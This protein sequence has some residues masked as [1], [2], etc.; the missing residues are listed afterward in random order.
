MLVVC[1]ICI[2]ELYFVGCIWVGKIF[3]DIIVNGKIKMEYDRK[4][5]GLL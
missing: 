5:K 1:F 2:S 4:F 3:D